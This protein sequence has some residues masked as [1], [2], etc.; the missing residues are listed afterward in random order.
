MWCVYV[1]VRMC[2]FWCKDMTRQDLYT[3]TMTVP[4]LLA[5]DAQGFQYKLLTSSSYPSAKLFCDPWTNVVTFYKVNVA[6]T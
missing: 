4:I 6:D 3:L 5:V 2:V 1:C